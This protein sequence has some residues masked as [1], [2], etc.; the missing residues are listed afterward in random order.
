MTL[1]EVMVLASKGYGTNTG[2]ST[3]AAEALDLDFGFLTG[4]RSST[5]SPVVLLMHRPVFLSLLEPGGHL[6]FFRFTLELLELL[7]LAF[8]SS[9]SYCMPILL[10]SYLFVRKFS[11]RTDIFV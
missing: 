2:F 11:F 4:V 5:A 9:C 3:T 6:G 8:S 10:K 7:E 1:E